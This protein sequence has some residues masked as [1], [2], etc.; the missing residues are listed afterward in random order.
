MHDNGGQSGRNRQPDDIRRVG[1]SN[2]YKPATNCG[3]DVIGMCR[4]RADPFTL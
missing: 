4:A 1:L 3:R 2:Q